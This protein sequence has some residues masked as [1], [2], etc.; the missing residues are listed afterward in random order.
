MLPALLLVAAGVALSFTPTTMVIAA[1]LPAHRSGLASGLAGSSTQVGAS[2][3]LAAFTAVALVAGRDAP[4]QVTTIS[5]GGFSAAFLA[6]AVVALGTA[7][8]T[9]V[10]LVRRS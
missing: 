6:A 9:L 1:A 4:A 10:L 8:A 3:G 7:G 2:V 5:S